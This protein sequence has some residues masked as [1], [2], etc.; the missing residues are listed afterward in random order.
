MPPWIRL[1]LL[2]FPGAFC[3]AHVRT[4]AWILVTDNTSLWQW[5]V[6]CNVLLDDFAIYSRLM[7]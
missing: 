1:L 2:V 5:L 6:R 4:F 7:Y 3:F